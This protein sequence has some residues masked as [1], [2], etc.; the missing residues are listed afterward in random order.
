MGRRRQIRVAHAEIDDIGPSIPCGRLGAI[1]L[2]E[3]V[4]RQTADAVKFFHNLAPA[5]RIADTPPVE[6]EFGFS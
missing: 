3:Y 2:L 4:R 1:D 6:T 5:G